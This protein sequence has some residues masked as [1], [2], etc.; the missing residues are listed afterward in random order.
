MEESLRKIIKKHVDTFD[1]NNI[2]DI[3]DSYIKDRED[4]IDK[5]DPTAKYFT[6]KSKN[7]LNMTEHIHLLVSSAL[8]MM[9]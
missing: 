7:V 5:G 4:R 8:K 6:G 1:R 2:R 3:I 9:P